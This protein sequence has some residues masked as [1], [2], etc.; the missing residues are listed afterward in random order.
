MGNGLVQIRRNAFAAT[1]RKDAWWVAPAATAIGLT[2][3]G[4]YMGW[5]ALQGGAY[6]WGSYLSPLYSPD[7]KKAF[8][9]NVP[10]S[11]AFL[12]LAGPLSFR[13]TCYYY[14][15]AYYRAF[16]ISPP[17]C[18]VTGVPRNYGGEAKWPLIIQNIHRYTLYVALFF[19]CCLTYDAIAAFVPSGEKDYIVGVGTLVLVINASLLGVYTFSCH[20]FRHLVGGRR[21]RFGGDGDVTYT[22]WRGVSWLNARH[23][24]WAWL[25][26]F[27]VA[28][29]DLYVRM[30]AMGIWHDVKIF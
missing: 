18:A 7:I 6:E 26:L 8:A 14:R 25:S 27:W 23:M 17:A 10:F 12:I 20:S 4:A 21:D 30:V 9:I 15:K 13:A 11:G 29:S 2:I 24:L 22:L 3:A 16:F 5:A 1:E 28:F 19:I